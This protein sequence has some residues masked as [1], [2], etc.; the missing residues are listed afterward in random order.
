[1]DNPDGR[2]GGGHSGTECLPTAKW[3]HIAEALKAKI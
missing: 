3:V 1:M 2:G